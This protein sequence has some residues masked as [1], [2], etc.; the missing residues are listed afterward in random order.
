MERCDERKV[1]V[2]AKTKV[3]SHTK[4]KERQREREIR[5]KALKYTN[6]NNVQV[7]CNQTKGK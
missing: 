1:Y 7:G 6:I 5:H 2:T 4:A 3:H